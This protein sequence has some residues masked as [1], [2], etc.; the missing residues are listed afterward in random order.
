MP[1]ACCNLPS[2]IPPSPA[3]PGAIARHWRESRR[4]K[5]ASGEHLWC[6]VSL[7]LGQKLTGRTPKCCP[8]MC[9]WRG[10]QAGWTC[11][12]GIHPQVCGSL[13]Q[14]PVMLCRNYFK[15]CMRW[16]RSQSFPSLPSGMNPPWTD[17]NQEKVFKLSAFRGLRTTGFL[18]YVSHPAPHYNP[19]THN[20]QPSNSV[21]SLQ[22]WTYSNT[23][24]NTL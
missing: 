14:H 21:S 4:V 10:R 13:P 8:S 20:T 24:R 23:P 19:I 3:D 22:E 6:K 7:H 15:Q 12:V 2:C 9:R 5:G 1:R 17:L 16:R 11:Q 18:L